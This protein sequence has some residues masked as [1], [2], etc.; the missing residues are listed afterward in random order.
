[1]RGGARVLLLGRPAAA[2]KL[3]LA[4]GN[5][6]QEGVVDALYELEAE[7]EEVRIGLGFRLEESES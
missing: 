2:V 6:I 1:V 3:L 4:E 5:S 7:A